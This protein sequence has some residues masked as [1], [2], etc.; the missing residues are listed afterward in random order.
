MQ[1]LDRPDRPALALADDP[2]FARH[3]ADV[4]HPERPE[5]LDAARAA[6]ARSGADLS[7]VELRGR[8]AS[9]D[10]LGRVHS[11]RYLERLGHLAGQRGYLDE[12]T[13]YGPDSVAAARRA[14]GGALA[15]VDA[16][17]AGEA[18][19]GLGLLRPPGHHAR[20][21]AAMGFCL[22]NNVAVA[23]A[24][25]RARGLGRVA[26]VDW[27]VHHGN[28]TQE[29][30]YDDPSVLYLSL[31]Q[32]R[33]Y[34]GTGAV[35]ELGRDDARGATANIPLG[36][37]AGDAVYEAAVDRIVA[38]LI[39][40]FDPDL[41]LVSAGY[42]AHERD[43]LAQMRL[44]DDGYG[45]MT[46]HLTRALPRGPNGRLILLLEGG[47]DLVGLSGGLGATLRALDGDVPEPPPGRPLSAR[48]AEEL[49]QARRALAPFW[50]L[51]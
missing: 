4:P 9:D 7:R 3:R 21:D 51:G 18:C 40:D 6:L 29:M 15:L 13:Y 8:D 22:L 20:P 30:F 24:H 44:S 5:R 45:R 43:P 50:K 41:L 2:L 14:A 25:A 46:H 39:E 36:A 37:G 23:A 34:P 27:D 11:G 48:H 26:I 19:F 28:G 49:E 47:Y 33:F 12:D 17:L 35:L 42:D 10:E 31:H 1:D 38:P 16:L 32:S